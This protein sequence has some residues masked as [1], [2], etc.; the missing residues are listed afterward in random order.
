MHLMSSSEDWTWLRRKSVSWKTCQ[1]EL[2]KL[3]SKEMK[4]NQTTEYP[5]TVRQ[6][7]K[8]NMCIMGLSEGEKR[9]KGIVEIAKVVMA[10][11]I[12]KLMT[13]P[14]LRSRKLRIPKENTK[15][16][17]PTHIIFKLQKIKD[18]ENSWNKPKKKTI[19]HL[20][21]NKGKNYTGLLFKNYASKKRAE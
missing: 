16:S 7:Q 15:K 11:N 3:K 8:S 1:Q 18:K 6:L 19:P 2:Q 17:T 21:R 4:K 10:N 12:P 9:E 20:Q 5:R 14:N 13:E